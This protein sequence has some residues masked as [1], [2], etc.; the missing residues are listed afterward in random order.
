MSKLTEFL[1]LVKLARGAITSYACDCFV[2]ANAHIVLLDAYIH[3]S[4]TRVIEHCVIVFNN[5]LLEKFWNNNLAVLDNQLIQMIG[6][7]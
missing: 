7:L 1:V 6:E 2:Q 5:A 3:S 4:F